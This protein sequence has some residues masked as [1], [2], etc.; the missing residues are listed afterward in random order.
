MLRLFT[1]YYKALKMYYQNVNGLRT[2]THKI[3]QEIL[4]NNYDIIILVE[5]WLNDG[6]LNG[7][8]CDGRYDI[9]R[10]DR[11]QVAT[12]MEKGGGV[13]VCTKRDLSASSTR[14]VTNDIVDIIWI[15]IPA[16]SLNT[17]KD[18]HII[19]AYI[20][21]DS[22]QA[23]HLC[24]LKNTVSEIISSAPDSSFLI[25]GDFN[26]PFI[27]WTPEGPHYLNKGSVDIRTQAM[28]LIDLLS[29][30]GLSQHNNFIKN[31][32][33]NILDLIFSNFTT[34]VTKC[35]NPLVLEDKHH[36]SLSVKI[37][38]L[39][40]K[41][42]CYAPIEKHL[43]HKA[44]YSLI[45]EYLS[46]LDWSNEL[47]NLEV[48]D[49]VDFFYRALNEVIKEHVP[50]VTCFNN[51]HFPK[52]YSSSLIRTINEKDKAHK[53]WK[54]YGNNNDYSEFS[55]L[56]AR[57][58]RMQKVCYNNF[59]LFS[60][61]SIKKDPKAFWAFVKSKKGR[62]SYPTVVTYGDTSFCNGSDICKGFNDFFY[63]TFCPKLDNYPP[64]TLPSSQRG[65]S[66]YLGTLSFTPDEIFSMLRK[67]DVDKSAGFDNIPPLMIVKC[68]GSLALPLSILFNKSINSGTFPD[69]WKEARVVPIHK[70][71]SIRKI[72]NYRPISILNTFSKVFEKAA[73]DNL[74]PILSKGIPKEQHGFL[75]GKST[76]SNLTCFVKNIL[77]SMEKGFQVDVVYTDFEKAF[78]RVDHAIL[79]T[80]LSELGIH[81]DLLRWIESY[82]ENRSQAV[83]LGGFRSD[84]VT[85]PS[86]VPQGSH[87]GPILY[88]AF[89][90]DVFTCFN[91]SKFLM[92]ADDTKIYHN[93]K[94]ISDAAD[95]QSDLDR[96]SGYYRKNRI[97][98]NASKCQVISFTYKKNTVV[99]DYH[100]NGKNIE[101]V[102]AVRDLG[103]HLDP[104]LS[105]SKH[106]DIITN[107]AYRS[108]G[109]VIRTCSLFTDID[110][111]KS[112][113]FTH[114]RSILEYASPVWSPHYKIHQKNIETIQKKFIKH[115]NYRQRSSQTNYNDSCLDHRIMTLESRRTLLDM[116]FFHDILS[117]RLDCP[118]LIGSIGL[119]APRKRT[120]NTS[121]FH[122]PFHRTNYGKNEP[123]TRM[124][125]LLN[126]QFREL[127]PFASS[128]S[129]LKS[130]TIKKLTDATGTSSSSNNP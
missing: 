20:S 107:R 116:L 14:H 103:V 102:S 10:C 41:P 5:T 108:L 119:L 85:I 80:K 79:I 22:N 18:L 46:N 66:D 51:R 60:Q 58:H 112:V 50:L 24:Y 57:Y 101:R 115:L 82:L 104:K 63:S 31:S 126:S 109:F 83:V 3:Y 64:T 54:Q 38:D 9:F 55:L 2:K 34:E 12:G 99:Y 95:L 7:E 47:S 30:N 78:D 124:S 40:Y 23:S 61:N 120:R 88:N 130:K 32:S 73:H 113:Y 26:L 127:D 125:Q 19:N 111:V 71:G 110:C 43:F 49:A 29:L 114:V 67:L 59:V 13:M 68:A 91:F 37:V 62:S 8:L 42:L 81:G 53:R 74:Y 84:L 89:L 129:T 117:S 69:P 35:D 75:R 105:F 25:L 33:G 86:G 123:I 76:T 106:I 128:K 44:N 11:N 6:I 16:L 121:T 56:R 97:S 45:N 96:L 122:V 17:D 93:I 27:Q 77:D 72:E 36:P 28:E 90:Y 39:S 65:T 48:N 92:F 52:W 98:I 15:T 118:E 94:S 4:S 21:G 100:I 1:G 87:L 70:K